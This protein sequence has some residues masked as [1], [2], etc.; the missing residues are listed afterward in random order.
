MSSDRLETLMSQAEEL[1]QAGRYE[2]AI[3][4]LQELRQQKPNKYSLAYANA[5]AGHIDN[6]ASVCKFIEIVD[7]LKDSLVRNSST[8]Q[9]KILTLSTYIKALR[10]TNHYKK[11]LP[12]FLDT[13][14]QL[15]QQNRDALYTYLKAVLTAGKEDRDKAFEIYECWS[16]VEPANFNLLYSYAMGLVDTRKY[17]RACEVFER[18]LQIQPDNPITLSRYAGALVSIGQTEKAIQSFERSLQLEPDDPITLSRYARALT[19]IGQTEKA[20]QSFERSLQLEPDNP[21]TLSHY[22]SALT[23][24]GQTEKAI[25]SF[26]RSLQLEPDDP[27]T[28]SHYASALDS[29]GQTEKAIQSF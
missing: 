2:E 15:D 11:L 29:I 25:Q 12:F 20:I 4:I 27:I 6:L 26:E 10:V 23:S 3:I 8:F 24:I 16:W 7:I 17:E 5:L 13:W 21:T 1:I 14:L 22:A 28:L 18:S 9:N 19:S